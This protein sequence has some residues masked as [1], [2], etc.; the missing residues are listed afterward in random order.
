MMKNE[1]I[2]RPFGA[3]KKVRCL[4]ESLHGHVWISFFRTLAVIH[5]YFYI[6]LISSFA[7]LL[8]LCTQPTSSRHIK[9]AHA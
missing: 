8:L 3:W 4:E 5:L 9:R 1:M 2:Y 7:F 6:F